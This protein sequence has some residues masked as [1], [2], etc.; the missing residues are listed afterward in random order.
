MLTVLKAFQDNKS[1]LEV[2]VDIKEGVLEEDVDIGV[3]AIP[4]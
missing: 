1:W 4:K 3:T 2:I